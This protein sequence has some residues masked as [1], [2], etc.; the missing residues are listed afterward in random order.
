MLGNKTVYS[1]AS[2]MLNNSCYSYGINMLE[3]NDAFFLDLYIET[4]NQRGFFS[5]FFKFPSTVKFIIMIVICCAYSTNV[6]FLIR[7]C[8]LTDCFYSYWRISVIKRFISL[9]VNH[10]HSLAAAIL[11]LSRNKRCP[12]VIVFT[13]P[14]WKYAHFHVMIKE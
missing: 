7:D 11:H 8:L 13:F 10:C 6:M 3:L 4:V 1:S 14:Y 5:V 9:T 12:F 2:Y